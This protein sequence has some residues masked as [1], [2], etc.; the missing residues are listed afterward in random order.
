MAIVQSGNIQFSSFSTLARAGEFTNSGNTFRWINGS[1]AQTSNNQYAVLQWT[2]SG[3]SPVGADP[4]SGS[5]YVNYLVCTQLASSIP[6]GS[7]INGITVKIE[8]YNG[9]GGEML[10]I[11]DNAIYLTKDGTNTVGS[12]KSAGVTW[13]LT[14]PNTLNETFGSSSDLWGTTFTAAE[15]NASTFGVM[16]SPNLSIGGS[17]AAIG[18]NVKIDQIIVDINYTT[19]GVASRRAVFSTAAE[20]RTV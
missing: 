8:R 2:T 14:D 6:A 13:S 16:I 5:G 17:G 10:T 1:N 7:T 18:A 9:E 12:N 4:I 20:L 19:S 3:G 15:V 11:T